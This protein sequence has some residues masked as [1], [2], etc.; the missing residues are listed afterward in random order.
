MWVSGDSDKT[1]GK[2][3]SIFVPLVCYRVVLLECCSLLRMWVL[4]DTLQ[5]LLAL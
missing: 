5:H 3:C 1:V 4:P 2:P